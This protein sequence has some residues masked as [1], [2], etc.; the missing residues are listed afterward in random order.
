MP[1]F[2]PL[3][4]TKVEKTTRDA[5]AVTLRPQDPDV[6]R[7]HPGQY[8][9]FRKTF[10]GEELR[11]SYSICAGLDDGCLQVGVK[12]VDGGTFSTWANSLL[13]EG[14]VVE[15]QPPQGRFYTELTPEAARHYLAFAA[16]SGITPVL[17]NIR[18]ILAREPQ[19]R[20]TLVYA[21]R[22]VASIMFREELEDLKNKHMGRLNVIHIL[23]ADAQ[24]ID[25]FTGRLDAE[26][27]ELLF[28]H[29]IDID[30]V[31]DALV[32]GPEPLMHVI[33]NS[34]KNHGIPAESI[35]YE[36]FG[37]Q[38]GRAPKRASGPQS[39]GGCRASITIDGTTHEIEV[40]REGQSVLEAARAANLDAPFSCTAGVCST[41]RAKVLEGE[42]EMIANHALEEY[43][44]ARGYV[45]T[46]QS[47]PLTDRLVITYDG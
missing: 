22:S 3:T 6:F 14:D 13:A 41:C 5:V 30:S 9:T 18:T 24:D 33:V 31:T 35:K 36:L 20:I 12:R 42:V 44:I 19:A 29:W 32:C 46:C 15:A 43:E 2:F 26:K 21:N 4:V 34:L 45:L 23:A 47:Y 7:F 37:A 8:L 39:L 40:A 16:G 25:L 17:S 11:R 27:L 28:K 10:D 38:P 1:E